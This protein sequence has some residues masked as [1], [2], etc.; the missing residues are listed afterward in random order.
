MLKPKI[1]YRYRDGVSRGLGKAY[2]KSTIYCRKL[3][4]FFHIHNICVIL[5]L[6]V[7]VSFAL[8]EPVE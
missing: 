1:I 4:D 8:K 6:P 5:L 7:A 2:P 3:K